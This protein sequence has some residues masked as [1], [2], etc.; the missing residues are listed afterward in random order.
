MNR[1]IKFRAWDTEG[2]YWVDGFDI[3]DKGKIRTIYYT[4]A[5]EPGTDITDKVILEQ[6]TGLK[7]KNGKE[8]WEGDIVEV[9]TQRV[10]LGSNWYQSTSQYDGNC[11]ARC[12]IA[13]IDGA[14]RL[15]WDTPHNNKI[16]ELKGKETDKRD[17]QRYALNSNMLTIGT[18]H[19]KEQK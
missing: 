7:D 11:T 12:V 6:Y 4:A 16:L 14:F 9:K 8:R 2:E 19:D 13:F 1:E 18:I 17:F 15:D 10:S 3:T 5:G